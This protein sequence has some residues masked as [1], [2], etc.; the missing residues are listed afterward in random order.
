M[1]RLEL[2]A[3]TTCSQLVDRIIPTLTPAEEAAEVNIA[4]VR[5]LLESQTFVES[6]RSRGN[7][8]PPPAQLYN[9]GTSL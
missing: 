3:Q 7:T 6:C 4:S 2:P 5:A 9:L 8:S 1:L